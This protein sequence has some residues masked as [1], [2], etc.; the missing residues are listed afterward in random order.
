MKLLHAGSNT[1]DMLARF[2]RHEPS[3]GGGGGGG[4]GRGEESEGLIHAAFNPALGE[5]LAC[6]SHVM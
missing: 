5:K 6:S 1:L 2:P 4:G 3:V